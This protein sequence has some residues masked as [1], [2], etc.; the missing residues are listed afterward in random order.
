LLSVVVEDSLDEL[1]DVLRFGF[2]SFR[3]CLDVVTV[4]FAGHETDFLSAGT[5]KKSSCFLSRHPGSDSAETYLGSS[6]DSFRSEMVEVPR[7]RRR[8][9]G[10]PL[11]TEG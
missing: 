8:V 7:L 9:R 4:G 3:Y 11:S 10:V 1:G 5:D 6:F 2:R